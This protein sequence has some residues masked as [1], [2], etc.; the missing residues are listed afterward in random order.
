MKV[1][2]VGSDN[3]VDN[4]LVFD[5]VEAAEAAFPSMT[6]IQETEDTNAANVNYTWHADVQKFSPVKPFPSWTLADDYITWNAPQEHPLGSI[7]NG[8]IYYWDEAVYDSGG[9]GWTR[10]GEGVEIPQ[11]AS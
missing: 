1:A 2:I 11:P 6:C 4:I 10:A 7:E 5:T 8:E 9:Q 3:I